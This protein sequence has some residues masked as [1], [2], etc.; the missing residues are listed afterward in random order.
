M[1]RP[2]F[3]QDLWV[4]PTPITAPLR[5]L[6][7]RYLLSIGSNLGDRVENLERAIGAIRTLPNSRVDA[8]SF[9]ASEPMYVEDQPEFLNAAVVMETPLAP[10]DLLRALQEIEN[11][12]G[13]EREARYG[14]RTIDIDIVGAEDL[15]IADERLAIPHARMHERPF[16]LGPLLELEPEWVHPTLN[17]T[18]RQLHASLTS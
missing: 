9:H 15:V 1:P 7:L 10:H 17:A 2:R 13:R 3:V 8:S 11:M 18:I 4:G 12:G 5:R 6:S 16:V 14:P